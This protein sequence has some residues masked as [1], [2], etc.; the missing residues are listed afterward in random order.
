MPGQIRDASGR[1]AALLVEGEVE[2]RGEKVP[3]GEGG[4]TIAEEGEEGDMQV[5]YWHCYRYQARDKQ[6]V[7]FFFVSQHRV[8]RVQFKADKNFN[9]SVPGSSFP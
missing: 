1:L 8:F 6:L 3:R 5:E 4:D 9:Q 2:G 7:K